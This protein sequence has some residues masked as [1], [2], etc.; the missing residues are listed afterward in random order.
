M[1]A[2]GILAVRE[3]GFSQL[4]I[5]EKELLFQFAPLRPIVFFDGFQRAILLG[6][7]SELGMN[8]IVRV[9]MRR[10]L[11][12]RVKRD[13]NARRAGGDNEHQPEEQ[14]D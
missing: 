4:P 1:H 11:E 6:G 12:L 3:N 9:L 8:P 13:G 2:L 5:P 14:K 7:K 10:L